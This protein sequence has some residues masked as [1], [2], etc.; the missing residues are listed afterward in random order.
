MKSALLVIDIQNLLVEEKPYAIE[1]RLALWQDSITKARQAGIEI[2][3]VRQND[4]ELVKGTADWEIHS[5]VAPL[6]S[7]K[8][9]DKTFNSAFK[10]TGLHAYLQEKGI[11]QLIIM[12]MATNFC[13]DTTIKVAFE[14]GY[15]VAV[16]RDGTTTGYSGKLDAEDLIDHYQNIW[17]W[18]F[19]QVDRLE[20]IIRG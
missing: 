7:E 20:N 16:I 19:A 11:E 5:I 14:L 3:Y 18:N 13:I 9:F 1:E 8:I 15:K 6:A 10:E 17:S 2:I 12:G 4:E